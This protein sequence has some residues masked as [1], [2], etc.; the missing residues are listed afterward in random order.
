PAD[1]DRPGAR[2]RRPPARRRRA[3]VGS[4]RL[5]PGADPQPADAPQGAAPPEPAL[6][7][8]QP[9]R[10]ALPLPARGRDVRRPDRRAGARRGAPP[11]PPPPL[12]AAA[13]LVDPR[14][15]GAI[16][17]AADRRRRRATLA[18]RARPRLPLPHALPARARDLPDDTAAGGVG[19]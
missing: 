17:A 11:P 16:P 10:R 1:R 3:G 19:R 2:P 9:R 12:H 15:H 18:A 13:R 8:P 5:D 6:H 14:A 4:R 7:L